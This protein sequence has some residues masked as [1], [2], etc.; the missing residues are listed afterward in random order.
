MSLIALVSEKGS[1]GTTTLGLTL[2]AVW[3]RRVAL[4][5]CDPAGGDLALRLVDS[6]GRPFLHP[7]PGLL[8]LAA[9][10][11]SESALPAASVWEHG[12]PFLGPASAGS[13]VLAG[14]NSP[15]QAT[16]LTGLWPALADA[17]A[18][19]DGGDVLADLGRLHPGSPA[20]AVAQ[21]SEVLVGVARGTAEGMLRLRDRLGHVLGAPPPTKAERRVLVVL[22]A[23]DRRGHEAVTA[24]RT[25]LDRSGLAAAAVG[26]IAVD[27]RAVAGLQRGLRGGWLDRT[28]LMRSARALVPKLCTAEV[29]PATA[30]REPRRRA[31][32][33]RSR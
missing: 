22:V 14:L 23:D 20:L 9:A 28:L 25:V 13:V 29:P 2:A 12:Q 16:G 27:N 24:M 8:T 5:E 3:P 26:F 33:A 1:P 4:V 32:L 10:V 18:A 7:E 21:A 19:T 17:L 30:S 6:T 15:E 31:V 11:R